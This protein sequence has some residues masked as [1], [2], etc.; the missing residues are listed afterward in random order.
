[1]LGNLWLAPNNVRILCMEL[2]NMTEVVRWEISSRN[3]TVDI[4]FILVFT[5]CYICTRFIF[6]QC[7]LLEYIAKYIKVASWLHN[8]CSV[9]LN[10]ADITIDVFMGMN[11]KFLIENKKIGYIYQKKYLQF[12]SLKI[13]LWSLVCK[14]TFVRVQRTFNCINM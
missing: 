14:R 7:S 4:Y 2:S 12:T 9:M 10:R 13:W 3:V 8:K 11:M 6:S 1:M 5:S